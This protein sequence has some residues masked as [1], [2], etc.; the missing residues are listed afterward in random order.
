MPPRR[1][2]KK[3]RLEDSK[4][5]KQRKVSGNSYDFYETAESLRTLFDTDWELASAA[6]AATIERTDQR[7]EGWIDVSCAKPP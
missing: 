4:F 2:R 6:L 5:W 7:G 3:W 1:R